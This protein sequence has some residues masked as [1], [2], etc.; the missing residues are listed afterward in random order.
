M[1]FRQ[2]QAFLLVV[3]TGTIAAAADHMGLTQSGVSRLVTELSRNVGFELFDRVGRGVK[4][5]ARGM[6]F[7]K[8]AEGVYDNAQTLQRLA[9]EIREGVNDRVRLSCLPTVATAVLPA[10]LEHFHRKYPNVF[11]DVHAQPPA[12]L[13][14]FLS[15]GKLDFALTLGLFQIDGYHIEP[16]A[17][18]QYILAVHK[19]HVLAQ[20]KLVGRGDLV[21]HSLIG[22]ESDSL[23]RPNDD[24]AKL[25]GE[26]ANETSKRIWCQSSMVRYA[27]LSNKRYVNVAEPFSFP[28]FAPHNIV[29]RNFTPN[30]TTEMQIVMPSEN[31]QV[32]LY[33]DLRNWFRQATTEFAIRNK[34][35]IKVV[36]D[37]SA[38]VANQ[39]A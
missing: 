18:S 27:L 17:H 9:G 31:V 23:L 29:A 36:D 20:K 14:N 21:G 19:D 8:V 2:I 6:A 28:L 24:E 37:P 16:F 22:F 15:S 34:L 7:F 26:A 10:V 30:V 1:T 32:P 38:S 39:T 4:P 5:T 35:P 12:E 13:P 33:H 11:V 3:R 25:I